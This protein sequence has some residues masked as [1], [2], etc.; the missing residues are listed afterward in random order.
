M[1]ADVVV[2]DVAQIPDG[3][4][5][6][7]VGDVANV[8]GGSTP[9][10]TRPE[11]WGGDIPWVVPSELTELSGRYLQ[12]SRESITMDGLESAG[13]RVLPAGSVL[14]TTRATIGLAAINTLPMATN[15]GFQ[16]LVG[17]N[18]TDSLWLY[19]CIS[20]QRSELERRGAGST[21][22]EVSRDG[23][24]TL[25]ILL[26]PLSEQR[27][28]AGV[29]DSIDEAI[30]RADEVITA[31]ERLSDALL[32]ELLTRGLP[33]QHSEWK[34]V[35]GVGTI[36]VSW[37]VA[38]LGE[39]LKLEYGVSL[40]ERCRQPG[41]TPV[42]GSAGIVGFHDHAYLSGPGVV[43]G[44]KGSIGTVTWVPEDFTPIDTTYFVLPLQ[45]R[46]NLRWAYYLL[47]QVDLASLNRATGVPGLNR[48]DVY[49][50][51]RPIPPLTEQQTI[52]GAL[53]SVRVAVE[54]A[55]DERETLQE[56]QTS[57]ADAL[58][59]GRVRVDQQEQKGMDQLGTDEV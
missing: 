28:I 21:F 12:D 41:S 29:L 15:Q 27:A 32:H 46:A 51:R 49:A 57:V 1:S 43:V 52:A 3:W 16:S 9:S 6:A 47:D 5:I 48:D 18:G 56:L 20:S 4:R 14:L 50:L 23:V 59:T 31:T 26:P 13:L 44:R 34:E 33:G 45:G 7:R 11:F 36:P 8:V 30:E 40:P 42:V 35:P 55:R 38:R 17:K 39:V 24:R 10:R 58:L 37:Q 19:Y 25:P 53:D 22:R 2:R 54:Q